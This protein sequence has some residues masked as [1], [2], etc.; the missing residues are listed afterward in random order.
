M[1]PY[2]RLVHLIRQQ[3]GQGSQPEALS[4]GVALGVML[5]LFPV[6]GVTTV[7]CLLAAVALRLN[8]V[9]LQAS[10]Y[11]VYPLQVAM[12]GVYVSLGNLW[13]GT[14]ATM[15]DLIRL[16]ALLGA[17]VVAGGRL[18]TSVLLPGVA[19]WVITSP[20]LG[21]GIYFLSRPAFAKLR[22]TQTQTA[23]P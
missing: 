12:L 10:H 18:L 11:A 9:V 17:D 19:V 15:A 23:A 22:A 20:I 3:L 7:L 5:G 8:H 1:Q 2:R 16:P 13:F 14:G 21:A 6:P 4:T